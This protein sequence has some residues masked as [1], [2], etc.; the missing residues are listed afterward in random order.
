MQKHSQENMVNTAGSYGQTVNTC[1]LSQV[2]R[3]HTEFN[4][5][6]FKWMHSEI[7]YVGLS[8]MMLSG[9]NLFF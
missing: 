4:M 3:A 8:E 9:Q 5:A 6:H 2:T 7:P 1:A